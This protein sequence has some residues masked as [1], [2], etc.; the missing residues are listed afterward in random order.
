MFLGA[1]RGP[2]GAT[3]SPSILASVA[4]VGGGVL[5]WLHYQNCASK[6]VAES[7]RVAGPQ[8]DV[9]QVTPE[10]TSSGSPGA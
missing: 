5:A 6:W 1:L 8:Q 7:D 9:V 3:G 2:D 10:V 4:R